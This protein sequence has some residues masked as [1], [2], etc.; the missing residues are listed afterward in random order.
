MYLTKHCIAGSSLF[1]KRDLHAWTKCCCFKE[2]F[3]KKTL[4]PND[5]SVV[6]MA[7]QSRMY[8]Q[9]WKLLSE[10]PRHPLRYHVYKLIKCYWSWHWR[11][12]HS[13]VILP[14]TEKSSRKQKIKSMN[15]ELDDL[16]IDRSCWT[17]LKR[18]AWDDLLIVLSYSLALAFFF[19]FFFFIF[20]HI[21]KSHIYTH[22]ASSYYW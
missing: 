16:L 13:A 14:A 12:R 22:Y 15:Q 6:I 5:S 3:R 19:F 7:L 4:H 10:Q 8:T 11:H 17:L 1:A 18:L 20:F 2:G 9:H 21:S